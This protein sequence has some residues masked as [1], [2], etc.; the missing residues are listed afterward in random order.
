MPHLWDIHRKPLVLVSV[1]GPMKT[2]AS[3]LLLAGLVTA[4]AGTKDA[5]ATPVGC[6][7]EAKV[8]DDG[9]TVGRSGPACEF[10]ACPGPLDAAE[11]ASYPCEEG[12]ECPGVDC[13]GEDCPAL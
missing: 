2:L 6:T 3:L 8:C 13:V 7:E 11:P 12:A 9:S 10:E 1:P 5:T 4:C